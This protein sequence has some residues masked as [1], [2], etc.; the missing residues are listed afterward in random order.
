MVD[1]EAAPERARGHER[2]KEDCGGCNDELR[3]LVRDVR[4]EAEHV[5][6][7]LDGID[8]ALV[9]TA[10]DPQTGELA[11]AIEVLG[12]SVD[13]HI[14]AVDERLRELRE[15]L[16]DCPRL[17]DMSGDEIAEMANLWQDALGWIPREGATADACHKG[18]P[19]VRD[20]LG[21]IAWHAALVTVPQRVNQHLQTLRVGGQLKFGDA[22]GDEL[23]DPTDRQKMLDYLKAHPSA[24]SGIVDA[25]RGVIYAA[26]RS[27]GRRLLSVGLLV[28]LLL[29]G[30]G[31][32]RVA[33]G[34]FPPYIAATWLFTT[35]RFA[36]LVGAYILLFVGAVVHI[37]IEAIKE[38]QR[39][40]PGAF[41]ALDDWF[42]WLHVREVSNAVSVLSLWAVIF[43]LAVGYPNGIDRLSAVF[44]GYSLDSVIG[45]AITRF[46]ALA[47]SKTGAVA[48]TLSG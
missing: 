27:G 12:R 46:D 38:Q 2:C 44:A 39:N 14:A 20:R 29:A 34:G 5:L 32:I 30:V 24:V 33:T 26:S 15:L 42:L 6:R 47:S 31:V 43:L 36:D 48:K 13:N 10:P 11:A 18:V 25:E 21:D 35:D 23:P 40:G 9:L 17:Y 45:I 19:I 22:F 41:L 1:E 37:V 3:G 4:V 7:S 8:A 16:R 28:V